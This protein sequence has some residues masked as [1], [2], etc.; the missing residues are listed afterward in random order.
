MGRKIDPVFD[1][2][3]RRVLSSDPNEWNQRYYITFQD[4]PFVIPA[5]ILQSR[6]ALH[7]EIARLFT[8]VWGK[9]SGRSTTGTTWSAPNTKSFWR[10]RP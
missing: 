8:D 9:K 7:A 2:N 4:N 6:K 3:A 10:R 1:F 5:N